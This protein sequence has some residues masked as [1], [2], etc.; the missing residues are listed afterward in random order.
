[1]AEDRDNWRSNVFD[2]ATSYEKS[3][4][5]DAEESRQRRKNTASNVTQNTLLNCKFCRRPCRSRAALASH[6]RHC[7]RKS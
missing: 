4:I 6:E 5:K 7:S 2:G 3:R 1:M